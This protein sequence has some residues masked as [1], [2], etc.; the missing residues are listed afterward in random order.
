MTNSD[1]KLSDRIREFLFGSEHQEDWDYVTGS[2]DLLS[3]AAKALDVQEILVQRLL[4]RIA[5]TG[6]IMKPS[7]WQRIFGFPF[8]WNAA[9]FAFGMWLVMM[10]FLVPCLIVAVIIMHLLGIDPPR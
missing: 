6:G 5:E 8:S 1:K 10:L 4:D 2:I 3:E 9:R 7:L